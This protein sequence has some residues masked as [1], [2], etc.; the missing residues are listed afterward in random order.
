MPRSDI[1]F[2]HTVVNPRIRLS[3]SRHAGRHLADTIFERSSD[4]VP[5]SIALIQQLF[6][7]V[8]SFG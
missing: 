7:L 1:S 2:V 6:N 5:I 4:M 3:V 8:H